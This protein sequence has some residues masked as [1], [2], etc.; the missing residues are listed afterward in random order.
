MSNHKV[1]DYLK[2]PW[3]NRLVYKV[4]KIRG[5]DYELAF[6]AYGKD[7]VLTYT[8]LSIEYIDSKSGYIKANRVEKLLY[9]NF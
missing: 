3:E 8:Y 1:G 7:H 5:H 9:G 6:L 4:T 2:R